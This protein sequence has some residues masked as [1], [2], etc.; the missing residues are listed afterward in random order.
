M[1]S[2]LFW[3]DFLKILS[4]FLVILLHTSMPYVYRFNSIPL[5]NWY[6]ANIFDSFSRIAVPIFFMISGALYLSRPC[7]SVWTFY[8]TKFNMLIPPLIF[9]SIIYLLWDQYYLENSINFFNQIW[10]IALYPQFYH[11]WFIYALICV[12]LVYPLVRKYVES[13]PGYLQMFGLFLSLIITSI[14]PLIISISFKSYLYY[15]QYFLLGYYLD[16]KNITQSMYFSS[17]LLFF[18]STLTTIHMTY[19]LSAL[20]GH[21]NGFFYDY[22]SLST[23]LQSISFFILAKHFKIKS[24]KI[25]KIYM[26]LAPMVFGV[27]LIHPLLLT[28]FN[29]SRLAI[30]PLI[31]IPFVTLVT[32]FIS[33]LLIFILRKSNISRLFI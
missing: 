29:Y 8:K 17:L 18:F 16:R 1:N 31:I 3:P 20:A 2:K 32:F 12:Y 10:K 9:W 27:Y 11:L 14:L 19:H 28:I 25:K 26:N 33:F 22:F 6:I 15:L 13:V 4:I 30:N 24:G 23:F 7:S 21:F 5:T